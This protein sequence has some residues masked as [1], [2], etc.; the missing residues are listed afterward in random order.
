M[1]RVVFLGTPQAAVPT[2][3]SLAAEHDVALIITQ[4]DRPRGRSGTPQAPPVKEAASARG[5]EVSQPTKSG[6]IASLMDAAGPFDV[7]VVVAYGRILR[8]E[9]LALPERG[10]L[11]I[12]FSLLPRWRGAAPVARA[13]MAGDE[14][15]GVTIIKLDE[16]LD[17]GPVLTAQAVDIPPDDDAGAL[18]DRLAHLGARLLLEVL[19]RYLA[20]DLEPV[21]QTDDGVV[22]AD[23]IEKEERPIAPD[24]AA[25]AV[26]AKVR[27][28]APEPAATLEI[29]GDRHKI[30]TVRLHDAEVQQGHWSV[31]D[32][33]PVVGFPGGGVELVTLQPPGKKAMSGADWV[34][35]RHS[36]RGAV[37]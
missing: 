6:D 8:P 7:G 4:P 20:G 29:D 28:L 18:T 36:S 34:R 9:A 33:V 10:L 19:P 14:M 35:G 25:P 32:G 30:L 2:L 27:G 37:S 17:T 24:T 31:V 12:H 5:L 16:G 22:Y 13:L 26:V 23:K 11:N 1:A 3:E 21:P 15:T